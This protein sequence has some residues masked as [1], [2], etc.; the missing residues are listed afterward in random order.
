[1]K[2]IKCLI[3]CCALVTCY[4]CFGVSMATAQSASSQGY[5][6]IIISDVRT[7]ENAHQLDDFIR[8]QPGVS[9][10]RMDIV[11][12]I[13]FGVFDTNSDVDVQDYLSWVVNLG[14]TP[15]CYVSS[16]FGNGHPI[17]KLSRES[18]ANG[19][20]PKYEEK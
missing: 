8:Q 1:M 17:A 18:C 6:K 4:L 5:V 9:L 2:R 14:F 3:T 13:Y 19:N 10:S 7:P 16:E 12:G 20:F 15:E 11:T